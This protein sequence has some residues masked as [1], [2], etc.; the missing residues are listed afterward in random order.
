PK[1]LGALFFMWEVETVL[2]GS[3]YGVNPFDQPAVEK[4]KR[5]TWGLMGRKGF[6]AEREEIE[7]WGG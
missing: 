6:E 4:G 5:L 7:A 2:L 3:F 1:A